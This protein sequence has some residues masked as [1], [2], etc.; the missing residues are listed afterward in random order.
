MIP[1]RA[2]DS[3]SPAESG[4]YFRLSLAAAANLIRVK[5]VNLFLEH[6]KLLVKLFQRKIL[7]VVRSSRYL[8]YLQMNK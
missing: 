2:R 8:A 5:V 1:S 4:S 3:L 7:R 6:E